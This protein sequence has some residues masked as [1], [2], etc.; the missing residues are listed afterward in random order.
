MYSPTLGRFMQ[1][2]PIGYGD[3][4]NNLAYVGNDPVN[5]I[6]PTGL[7][8]VCVFPAPTGPQD[9]K[10]ECEAAGGKWVESIVV[11]ATV[12]DDSFTSHGFTVSIGGLGPGSYPITQGGV[13]VGTV[14]ILPE[15]SE[16]DEEDL[17]ST[18]CR[19]VSESGGDPAALAS[20]L[21]NEGTGAVIGGVG[22]LAFGEAYLK[23]NQRFRKFRLQPLGQGAEQFEKSVRRSGRIKGGF[24]GA[25][26]GIGV[27]FHFRDEFDAFEQRVA[28]TC[29]GV[30]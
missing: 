8:F 14:T 2:D 24:L 19:I 12:G 15:D 21:A 23:F 28:E 11:T 9:S 25:I 26:A 30:L 17:T 7:T 18:F 27:T 6:D 29:R 4:M 1:T 5:R 22:A 20:L 16:N 13:T 3:G 10:R